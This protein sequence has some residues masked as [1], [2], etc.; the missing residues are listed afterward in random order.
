MLNCS[1]RSMPQT[2][3]HEG[4]IPSLVGCGFELT[5]T[6]GQLYY[7]YH[8]FYYCY[9]NTHLVPVKISSTCSQDVLN[10]VPNVGHC[11]L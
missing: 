8:F 11:N 6:K 4:I 2:G 3:E 7:L 10:L 5:P 9:Y 1:L